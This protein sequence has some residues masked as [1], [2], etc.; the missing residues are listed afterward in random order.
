MSYKRR[1]SLVKKAI[2]LSVLSNSEVILLVRSEPSTRFSAGRT[3]AVSC[4][5]DG[6]GMMETFMN[7]M[8]KGKIDNYYTAQDHEVL[9]QKTRGGSRSNVGD[10]QCEDSSS[11]DATLSPASQIVQHV[12]ISEKVDGADVQ[13]PYPPKNSAAASPFLAKSLS[14]H[15]HPTHPA[16]PS[17]GVTV[18]AMHL[19]RSP[20]GNASFRESPAHRTG[21]HE[22]PCPANRS[23]MDSHSRGQSSGL[24]FQ[25]RDDSNAL[26]RDRDSSMF[27]GT[28]DSIVKSIDFLPTDARYQSDNFLEMRNLLERAPSTQMDVGVEDEDREKS[29]ITSVVTR[30]I[31]F[32]G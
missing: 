24:H 20:H 10:A 6:L 13:A 14:R 4:S 22:S 11:E 18:A 15:F 28:D 27:P 29:P 23:A 32:D 9:Q 25:S 1:I 7:L 2:E 19:D 17:E 3:T 31:F 12:G 5:K 30:S 8:A 16:A 21:S 26:P